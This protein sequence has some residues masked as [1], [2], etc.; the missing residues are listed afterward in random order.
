MSAISTLDIAQ[1]NAQ[2]GRR[3]AAAGHLLQLVGQHVTGGADLACEAEA[4][5][6][7]EG[8]AE[9]AAVGELGEL[10]V[11]AVDTG[12]RNGARIGIVREFKHILAFG[13]RRMG[14]GSYQFHSVHSFRRCAGA[15]PLL[16]RGVPGRGAS[17]GQPA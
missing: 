7:Q 5:A 9:G 8:L 6:Q 10:Q 4:A 1:I 2:H 13:R 15:R 11:D 12:Q 14:A 17:G 16:R 3:E